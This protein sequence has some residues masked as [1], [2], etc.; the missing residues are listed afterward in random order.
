MNHRL[1][2]FVGGNMGEWTV[3]STR[4]IVGDALPAVERVVFVRGPVLEEPQ[5]AK[6]VLRG[7]TSHARYVTRSEKEALVSKQAAIGRPGSSLAALIPIRKSAAWWELT[8]DER[9][10]I[11]EEQSKH[12]L[13]SPNEPWHYH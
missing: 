8:Q 9:R 11:F 1:Y 12:N 7:I 2:S 13:L 5:G 6:W 4:T 10:A 3:L